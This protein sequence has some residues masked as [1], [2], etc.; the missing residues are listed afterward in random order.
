MVRQ[1]VTMLK[2]STAIGKLSLAENQS[3]SM[4]KSGF[5]DSI[6]PPPSA[7]NNAMLKPRA[8][9]TSEFWLEFDQQI[10]EIPNSQP[11]TSNPSK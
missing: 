8:Q 4:Q 3:V 1:R 7:L 5:K 2:L 10:N 11:T 9:T 6:A